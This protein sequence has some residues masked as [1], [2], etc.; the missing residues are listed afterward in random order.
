MY[1]SQKMIGKGI[2][3][4]VCFLSVCSCDSAK[5]LKGSQNIEESATKKLRKYPNH[6]KVKEELEEIYKD[7]SGFS[8]SQ[9]ERNSIDQSR[10]SNS[11]YGELTFEG[12]QKLVDVLQLSPDDVFFD[13]GS[14]VA[15][16][17]LYVYRVAGVRKSV[18]IELS[19]TRHDAA[20]EILQQVRK[21]GWIQP[22]RL[23]ELQHK[24]ILNSDFHDATVLYICSTC[25]PNDII[26]GVVQKMLQ[27]PRP[28]ILV[29]QKPIEHKQLQ[30]IRTVELPTTWNSKARWHIYR[31]SL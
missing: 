24:D 1:G 6:Q 8:V 12:I 28:V 23:L 17:V 25:Y 21:H 13:L 3:F 27:I 14:G 16:I 5:D 20:M 2:V 30:W 4:L 18:G 26:R 7:V 29:S 22:D 11:T 9:E 10:S 31:T 19:K 15:K